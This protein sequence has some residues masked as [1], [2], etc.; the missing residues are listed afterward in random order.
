MGRALVKGGLRAMGYTSHRARTDHGEVHFLRAK[1]HGALPPIVLLHGL[2]SR[3]FDYWSLTRRL[4]EHVQ[5]VYAPDL[6]GHGGSALADV[7]HDAASLTGALGA[8]LAHALDEP[9]IVYGNSLG[10]LCALRV[11]IDRPN[12]VR[13]LFLAS[14]A[15]AASSADELG[16]LRRLLSVGSHGD[17][18][19]FLDTVIHDRSALHHVLA[20]GLRHRF[21]APTVSAL[22]GELDTSPAFAP[23]E[24][25]GLRVPIH[26]FWGRGERLFPPSH[27]AFFRAHLPPHTVIDEALGFGHAPHLDDV[28]G[29][30]QRILRF[31]RSLPSATT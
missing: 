7:A 5:A 2:G 9:A 19:R 24:L 11:A 25:A 27:L 14:P 3:G 22:V 10:G 18:V 6:L 23:E 21:G 30:A 29:L 15:G 17:A 16:E 8:A 31:A 26:L 13:G 4:R 28:D 1:G 12:L 20:F